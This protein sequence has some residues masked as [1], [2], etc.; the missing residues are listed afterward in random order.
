MSLSRVAHLETTQSTND[1]AMRLAREGENGPLWVVARE[2]SGGRGRH[3]RTWHSPPG[4]LYASLLLVDPCTPD[5]A[6]QLGF[7]AGVALVEAVTALLGDNALRGQVVRLKWPNDLLSDGA[8]VS[9]ISLDATRRLDG[10]FACVIG[11]GVNCRSH[12]TDLPYRA[13]HLSGIAGRDISPTDLHPHL[14]RAMMAWIERWDRG[15]NF[16]IVRDAWLASAA[17]R[18]RPVTVALPKRTVEGTFETIDETGRLI[19]R[20]ATGPVTIDAGDVH[21]GG[22]SS[23][24]EP[25]A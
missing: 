12:P 10:A 22:V 7:V 24:R 20:T 15:R 16:A 9:G 13:A 2:Q 25:I 11:M 6:P 14:D 19:V 3:G 23:A 18:G 8:K 4:N 17:G 5:V 1:D 21:F